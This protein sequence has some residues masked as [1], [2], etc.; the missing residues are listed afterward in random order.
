[1]KYFNTLLKFNLTC[2][3][4]LKINLK[5]PDNTKLIHQHWIKLFT[6][7]I[8]IYFDFVNK[9]YGYQNAISL[10]QPDEK[11]TE[12]NL[13]AYFDIDSTAFP[14][15]AL[16]YIDS[17]LEGKVSNAKH[18][19]IILIL[20]YFIKFDYAFKKH[21]IKTN[22]NLL[23]DNY[24]R[25]FNSLA[26]L[27]EN[28]Y[29]ELGL[30]VLGNFLNKFTKFIKT[31]EHLVHNTNL[32]N[33]AHGTAL[34]ICK[35]IKSNTIFE[36][37]D[38]YLINILFDY[39]NG[40]YSLFE[41][42]LIDDSFI[43]ELTDLEINFLN[44]N[45][46]LI[47]LNF[48]SCQKVTKL[49]LD[50][51]AN[52][53]TELLYSFYIHFISMNTQWILNSE[54][55][56]NSTDS[57]T[58]FVDNVL[59]FLLWINK[60]YN[61]D[62]KL[63]II[64][65]N[66]IPSS[67]YENVEIF[68]DSLDE[69]LSFDLENDENNDCF[70]PIFTNK[71]INSFL[72]NLVGFLN[73]LNFE[74]FLL[75]FVQKVIYVNKSQILL[76]FL[77]EVLNIL[78]KSFPYVHDICLETTIFEFIFEKLIEFPT[79]QLCK[80]MFY[81]I[82]KWFNHYEIESIS[83]EKFDN[84][85]KRLSITVFLK[86][87]KNLTNLIRID[88]NKFIKFIEKSNLIYY[89]FV[90]MK[91]TK[92]IDLFSFFRELLSSSEGVLYFISNEKNI[93][94]LFSFYFEKDINDQINECFREI[95]SCKN[96]VKLSFNILNTYISHINFQE[97]PQINVIF[98]YIKLIQEFRCD[99]SKEIDKNIEYQILNILSRFAKFKNDSLLYGFLNLLS[100][101][102]LLNNNQIFEYLKNIK[103]SDNTLKI[104]LS[105]I[106]EE[107]PEGVKIVN[108][109]HLHSIFSIPEKHIIIPYFYNICNNSTNNCIILSKYKIP[110]LLIE[111]YDLYGESKDYFNLLKCLLKTQ[112][113][114]DL[115]ENIIK[116]LTENYQLLELFFEFF[117]D[118][119]KSST[120]FHNVISENLFMTLVLFDNRRLFIYD[121]NE[122]NGYSVYSERILNFYK[123]AFKLS[124]KIEKSFIQ[125]GGIYVLSNL[126]MKI[127]FSKSNISS[128][129][130]LHDIM[131][132]PNEMKWLWLNYELWK[133]FS[134]EIQMF[135]FN[136]I[137]PNVIMN[138]TDLL[139][140]FN[141]T[142]NDQNLRKCI[143]NIIMM[144]P[145]IDILNSFC[146]ISSK[147]LQLE[148]LNEILNSNIYFSNC[149]SFSTF[150]KLIEYNNTDVKML[151]LK[152]LFKLVKTNRI[153]SEYFESM[154]ISSIR[155][156]QSCIKSEQIMDYILY[157]DKNFKYTFP[158]LSY[159]SYSLEFDTISEML[160]KLIDLDYLQYPI[161]EKY[162]NLWLVFILIS[163]GHPISKKFASQFFTK[164]NE[165][166]IIDFINFLI[167]CALKGKWDYSPILS[168]IF[169]KLFKCRNI[170]ISK[171]KIAELIIIYLFFIPNTEKYYYNVELL[172]FYS[173]DYNKKSGVN[174]PCHISFEEYLNTL[175]SNEMNTNTLSF[176]FSLRITNGFWID[177]NICFELIKF[178][179]HVNQEETIFGIPYNQIFSYLCSVCF[180][181]NPNNIPS[182]C[183]I[184]HQY[185]SYHNFD[186]ESTVIFYV[187]AVRTIQKNPMWHNTFS[188]LIEKGTKI[189]NEFYSNI[190]N[191]EIGAFDDP[192]LVSKVY[193]EYS[194]VLFYWIDNF[195]NH[196]HSIQSK[197]N[198][199]FQKSQGCIDSI[200]KLYYSSSNKDNFQLFQKLFSEYSATLENNSN[201]FMKEYNKIKQNIIPFN[202]YSDDDS[203]SYL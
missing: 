195:S 90:C 44:F 155:A 185:F 26:F 27:L 184:F 84:Y 167:F 181:T 182:I 52:V 8:S 66:Q 55:L 3:S 192:I 164:M 41:N 2:F 13:A 79:T 149:N 199:S 39:F 116:F 96:N 21:N 112:F 141:S 178:I 193:T 91:K 31:G 174:F 127:P 33:V 77:I 63:N 160:N 35:F 115:F 171:S 11:E 73:V 200:R 59:F 29:R 93:E 131:Y 61:I 147:E 169:L 56:K 32:K 24:S 45:Q 19:D 157:D 161:E 18:Q 122:N 58:H 186:F 72:G 51:S 53:N 120:S 99:L 97:E 104:I 34:I 162:F 156:F 25:V 189:G 134:K 197:I 146:F 190:G 43:Q 203:S 15:E 126:I 159:I 88:N 202:E 172:S 175:T 108:P 136:D 80:S 70:S 170:L 75:L 87:M 148:C 106:S 191:S 109:Q 98:N 65:N 9:I 103:L 6:E 129:Y 14:H 173:I 153:D 67:F 125:K 119:I 133:C 95:F 198:L 38:K 102:S 201:Y 71:K 7:D 183:S 176:N 47:V 118:L 123:N 177:Y 49:S 5:F 23:V 130:S 85:I 101:F 82:E 62:S 179:I 48:E 196:R 16:A 20:R 110:Y 92:K 144:K 111:N 12:N 166:Q 105:F 168:L 89:L 128:L 1:M 40:I 94:F 83:L 78:S 158:I 36:E 163:C 57:L 46:N 37:N 142:I 68:P 10:I 194:L 42:E 64:R 124:A 187:F 143:W 28:K 114:A 74:D 165:E 154:I 50:S 151:S 76:L 135:V 145:P 81:F 140:C 100:E 117:L 188:L 139:V 4:F 69:S 60:T 132:Y 113:T 86:F 22:Q 54:E 17:L 138:D 152:I 137:F 30:I 121:F 107:S 150:F 180:T